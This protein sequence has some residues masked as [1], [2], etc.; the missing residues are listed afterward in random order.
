M[1]PKTSPQRNETF[2]ISIIS[3]DRQSFHL[4][5]K[6][7]ELV[8]QPELVSSDSFSTHNLCRA[9]INLWK[10]FI[11]FSFSQASSTTCYLFQF[12]FCSHRIG[13]KFCW[14]R[15]RLHFFSTL[16]NNEVEDEN[17]HFLMVGKRRKKLNYP[18][19]IS[20]LNLPRLFQV[21]FSP[22]P[23]SPL[24]KFIFDLYFSAFGYFSI[25]VSMIH[26]LYAENENLM[27]WK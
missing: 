9:I 15:S 25:L 20:Y 1:R 5:H 24:L 19:F 21:L 6:S 11:S 17:L 26:G 16:I 12:Q 2:F 8:I 7:L 27:C 4:S 3:F 18:A 22:F 13:I 10:I 14:F 23:V